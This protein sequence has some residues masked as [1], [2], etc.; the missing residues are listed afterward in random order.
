MV[1]SLQ[2]SIFR[3]Y[4]ITQPRRQQH[5][6]L[7]AAPVAAL[8]A[9]RE[10][11]TRLLIAGVFMRSDTENETNLSKITVEFGCCIIFE[12]YYWCFWSL[13]RN[14]TA[15]TPSEHPPARRG[16]IRTFS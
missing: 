7:A 4:W 5:A 8:Q 9:W 3:C 1:L 13:K 14:M 15:S 16:N 2:S 6:N 11:M 10:E 12:L